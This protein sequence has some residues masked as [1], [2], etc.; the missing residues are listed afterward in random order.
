M[1]RLLS[2]FSPGNWDEM[3]VLKQ[4]TMQNGLSQL[5]SDQIV[6]WLRTL[7]IQK[8]REVRIA[9]DR[10]QLAERERIQSV[11]SYHIFSVTILLT[12]LQNF[13]LFRPNVVG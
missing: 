10:Y 3:P 12:R 13:R 9:R 8:P 5:H 2:L 7:A 1:E 4:Q 11:S 6:K